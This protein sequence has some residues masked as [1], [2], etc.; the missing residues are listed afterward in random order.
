MV[1]LIRMKALGSLKSI[2]KNKIN[3]FPDDQPL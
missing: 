2:V 3:H 1:E